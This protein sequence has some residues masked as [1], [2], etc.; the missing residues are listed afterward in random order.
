M[1]KSLEAILRTDG[2]YV[3][4]ERVERHKAQILN[5]IHS[6]TLLSV[7]A[8]RELEAMVAEL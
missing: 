5:L 7:E 1:P 4:E 3:I 2:N 8:E 6:A